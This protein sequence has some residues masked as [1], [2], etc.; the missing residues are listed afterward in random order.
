MALL[1]VKNLKTYFTTLSGYVKAVDGTSFEVEEGKAT[2]LAGES[3][4][5]KT[6]TALSILR[7]LP[8]NG[9]IVGGKLLFEGKDIVKLD[10]DEV[11]EALDRL[12]S[13]ALTRGFTIES[14][15]TWRRRG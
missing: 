6:T 12:R 5:G 13:W 4:C 3:G 11:R 14:R 10:E 2:G 15:T 1:E 7:I 9:R 8:T